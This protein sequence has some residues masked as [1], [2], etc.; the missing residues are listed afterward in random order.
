[1][2]KILKPIKIPKGYKLEQIDLFNGRKKALLHFL[3]IKKL[4]VKLK[5]S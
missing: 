4:E 5:K 1:M 3:K 2:D